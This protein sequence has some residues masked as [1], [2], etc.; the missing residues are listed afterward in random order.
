M[1]GRHGVRG[2]EST[3]SCYKGKQENTDFQAARIRALKPKPT[4]RHLLQQDHTYSSKATPPKIATSW[5]WHTQTTTF[6]SLTSIVLFKHMNLL[7]PYLN[8]A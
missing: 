7:W 8:T 6:Y 3:E 1:V 4:V 2:A 5:A